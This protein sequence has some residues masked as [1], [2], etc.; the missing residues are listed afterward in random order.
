MHIAGDTP[1]PVLT[2]APVLA[3]SALGFPPFGE[4]ADA[5][6]EQIGYR[7]SEEIRNPPEVFHAAPTLETHNLANPGA[8]M[9]AP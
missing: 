2:T 1:T 4:R 5:G 8:S 3:A 7:N 6:A 9:A